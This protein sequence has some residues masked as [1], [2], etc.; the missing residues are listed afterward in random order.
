M[1]GFEIGQYLLTD[2]IGKDKRNHRGIIDKSNEYMAI[3]A[4]DYPAAAEILHL[5]NFK[6]D[7]TN[8]YLALESAVN[9][10]LVIFPSSLNVRNELE[11][12]EEREDGS[13]YMRY[14]KPSLE[15]MDSLLQMDLMKEEILGMQKSKK[16]NG[17]IVIEQ[18]PEAKSNNL[19]DDRSD[20]LAMLCFRLMELRAS[21]VLDKETK[22]EDFSKLFKAKPKAKNGNP[23]V[24]KNKRNPFMGKNP[25]S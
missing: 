9:Q 7:K 10:G 17:T 20:T 19:H 16:T 4:D 3:R 18:T 6:R 14:E 13:M 23:F 11:F 22:A 21:E 24:D 1:G 25:F 8:A 15:E 2:F 12:E 5:F